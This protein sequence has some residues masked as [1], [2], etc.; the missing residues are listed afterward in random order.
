MNL[1][2]YFEN[3]EGLGVLA[4]ADSAGKVDA[5]IY[6]RPHVTDE[7]TVAFIMREHLTHQNLQSNP[8]AA[9][10]FVEKGPGY[11]GKRLYLTKL[12]EESD[13]AL[14]DSLRRR[15]PKISREDASKEHVVYFR[16]DRIRPLVGNGGTDSG[17]SA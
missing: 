14:I 17:D 8:H 12:R 9:Y 7:N 16:I 3:T 2:D 10:L 5:A 4:T 11:V 13:P 15:T 6:A 1:Y